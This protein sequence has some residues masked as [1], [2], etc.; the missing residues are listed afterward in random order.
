MAFSSAGAPEED[1]NKPYAGQI[2]CIKMLE[3]HNIEDVYF[4][5]ESYQK[6]RNCKCR[7][8]G[9]KFGETTFISRVTNT[10]R[11]HLRALR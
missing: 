4:S 3:N 5:G 2:F 11:L 9:I 6:L 10:Q 7:F 8:N 1:A